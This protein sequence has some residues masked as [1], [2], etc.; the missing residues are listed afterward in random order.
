M[1][2]VL[3][4]NVISFMG[5]CLMVVCGYL[6]DRKKTF[7]VQNG[8]MTLF[9]IANV[10]L[11]GYAGIITNAVSI[12]RNVFCMIDKYTIWVKVFIDACLIGLNVY[13]NNR[14]LIGWLPVVSGVFYSSL[15]DIKDE[16]KFKI[17]IGLSAFP[18]IVYDICIMNY[19]SAV[20]D[21]ITVVSCAIGYIR[22]K[23]DC[24]VI[25]DKNAV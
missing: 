1:R 8:Q 23:K 16:R 18:W 15:M 20:F 5:S 11:K 12:L 9:V 4:A 19:S 13:F 22:V 10:M 14:G 3:I 2:L 21:V 17:V 24:E 7:M 6:K 25:S